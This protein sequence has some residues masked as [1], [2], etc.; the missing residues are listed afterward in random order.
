MVVIDLCDSD[1]EG[2][3]VKPAVR[4]GSSRFPVSY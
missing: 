4:R 3:D 1:S 2:E